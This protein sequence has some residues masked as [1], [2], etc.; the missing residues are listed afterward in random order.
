[1]VILYPVVT[2]AAL[3]PLLLRSTCAAAL[4]FSLLIWSVHGPGERH[5]C[6]LH[7]PPD[8][9]K[10]TMCLLRRARG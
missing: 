6:P 4:S 8:G 2:A 3:Q 10:P 7:D 5:L 1:M 9:Q